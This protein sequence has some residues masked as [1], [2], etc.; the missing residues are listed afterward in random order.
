[1]HFSIGIV[2]C[3]ITAPECC[4]VLPPCFH[5]LVLP[6]LRKAARN[7][8]LTF[9]CPKCKRRS[10]C[11]SARYWGIALL[12]AAAAIR[13]TGRRLIKTKKVQPLI[14]FEIASVLVRRDRV[15][16]P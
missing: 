2:H 16:E 1:V 12:I 4:D 11:N 13:N 7:V 8:S 15:A 9:V 14:T 6:F 5:A 10:R 3:P